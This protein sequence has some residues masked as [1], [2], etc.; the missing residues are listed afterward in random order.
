ML[1]RPF[2]RLDADKNA[3]EG[4]GIGLALSKR[5]TELMGGEIGLESTPGEG[6]TFWVRFPATEPACDGRETVDAPEAAPRLDLRTILYIEG[7]PVNLRLMERIL[8]K[9]TDIRLISAERSGIGLELAAVHRPDLILLDI[10]LPDMD[11]YQVLSRLRDTP[12]THDLPV[13]GISANANAMPRDMERAREAG[14]ADYLTKPLDIGQLLR[15]ID[16]GLGEAPNGRKEV[17]T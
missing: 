17:R 13:I 8:S 3:I 7:N 1:F 15:A 12:D 14:F 10:N 16:H 6:S 5:L 2:E 11:G 9:R 4:T